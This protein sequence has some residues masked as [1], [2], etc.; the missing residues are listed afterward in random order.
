MSSAVRAPSQIDSYKR[1]IATAA[2]TIYDATGKAQTAGIATNTVFADMGKYSA[3]TAANGDL[4][5]GIVTADRANLT[6]RK[7][8]QL[9][10]TSASV[11]G[12]IYIG[13]KIPTAQKIAELN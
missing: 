1:F 12:Y 7:V 4:P 2:T 13:D 10:A 9:P 8:R 3:V 11:T 6:L 5:A